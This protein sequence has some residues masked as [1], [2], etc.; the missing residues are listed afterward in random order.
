MP[1][2]ITPT[3]NG[4]GG[5]T[6]TK[7][8]RKTLT[9]FLTLCMCLSMFCS[10]ALAADTST[11]TE[12]V[13]NADGT[14]TETT[15]TTTTET[16]PTTGNV[17]VVVSIEKN[18][19]GTTTDGTKVN[20]SE[21]YAGTSLTDFNGNVLHA[22]W[23]EKG[24]ETRQWT[25]TDTG[26]STGQPEITVP[27]SPGEEI[28]SSATS[29]TVTGD[30]PSGTNDSSYDYTTTTT[31]DRTITAETSK[32]EITVS[33]NSSELTGISPAKDS[34]KQELYLN[35]FTDPD[36]VSVSGT[37]P[38][39][40]DYQFVGAGDYSKQ[41]ISRIIVVYEKDEDGNVRYDENGD[42]I[43]A[44]LTNTA[45]T[46]LTVNGVPTTDVNAVFDQSTGVR[47]S[48]FLL[49]DEDGNT[50]YAYCVDLDVTTSK[51][52][53]YSISNLEDSDYFT[54]EDAADHI[55]AI[56]VNGYW[57]TSNEANE[58]GEY[59]TG[60][61]A[62]IKESLKEAI[63]SGELADTVTISYRKDGVIVTE[64]I[65]VADLIDGLTEGEA[66]DM[67][68]AA[69]WSYSNGSL[70]VLDGKDGA[71][72]G[73][74]TY[75]DTAGGNARNTDDPEG[76]ARMTLLY[77]WLISLAP[78][79]GTTTVINEN[80]FVSNLSLTVGDKV[81]GAA[82]NADG[83]SGNDVYNVDVNFTLEFTPSENDDL[84]V[85]IK[86]TDFDGTE[87]EIVKRLAG[88]AAEGETYETITPD[89]DGNYTI[90]GLT[91][92]ENETF[93]FDLR[94]E[95]TQYLEQG[96]Y[97]YTSQTA[98][99]DQNNDGIVSES[100]N[101]QTLVGIAE[102]FRN[103]DISLAVAVSFDVDE[104]DYIYA[105]RSWYKEGHYSHTPEQPEETPEE[106]TP[107]EETPEEEVPE[108]PVPEYPSQENTPTDTPTAPVVPEKPS[109]NTPLANAPQT[110]DTVL[111]YAT[112]TVLSGIG[113]AALL[114]FE[115][116]RKENL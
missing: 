11:A 10:Q 106:E 99:S 76:M 92:S 16:D 28:S 63:A 51:G 88:T 23:S 3:K 1:L 59:Q 25:E 86:Y 8:L 71:I 104:N 83:D 82:A 100:E 37:A 55:R 40:Y 9:V 112:L 60:S 78:Q 24:T 105:A 70:A 34:N 74:T 56:A 113:L 39:G 109:E 98:D 69:I 13:K 65:Y 64:D 19:T 4:K 58:N 41:Y 101:Y 22:Q 6:L 42:P 95:G 32:V 45:G 91:L 116:K 93:T 97:I 77:N 30:L 17:T 57:G 33:E 20:G 73:G 27:L 18:T 49:K 79:E 80:N 72:V 110:G 90:C 38:D 108:Y 107:V 29:T 61:L 43:I 66:L 21:T 94:L 26:N 102:G 7:K 103:V 47:A 12:T 50:V 53:W 44:S 87:Q 114:I 46:V 115:Q 54:S 35:N 89:A 36:S 96:V 85:K 31:K 84:L 81:I 52:V 75:G 68:Q 62:K 5:Y 2:G 111:L 67:T 14:S 48:Q 15:T